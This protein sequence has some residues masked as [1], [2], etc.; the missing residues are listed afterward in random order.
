[1]L[2][3]FFCL[4]GERWLCLKVSRR[5]RSFE[6]CVFDCKDF[7]NKEERKIRERVKVDG[8]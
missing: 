7:K 6:L 8:F 1:M 2:F 3:I 5:V 4:G